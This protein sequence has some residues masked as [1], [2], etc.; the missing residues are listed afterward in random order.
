MHNLSPSRSGHKPRLC[1]CEDCGEDGRVFSYEQWRWHQTQAQRRTASTASRAVES[2]AVSATAAAAATS[3]SPSASLP[4]FLPLSPAQLAQSE[5]DPQAERWKRQRLGDSTSAEADPDDALL[6]CHSDDGEADQEAEDGDADNSDTLPPFPDLPDAVSSLDDTD[7]ASIDKPDALNANDAASASIED[8]SSVSSQA[9][10]FSLV[11][12]LLLDSNAGHFDHTIESV[13]QTIA[14]PLQQQRGR[15][16]MVNYIFVMYLMTF[17]GLSNTV[18]TLYLS[19]VLHVLSRFCAFVVDANVPTCT[20]PACPPPPQSP[21]QPSP[22]PPASVHRAH[23]SL[24]QASLQ[25]QASDD[26]VSSSLGREREHLS[27]SQLLPPPLSMLVTPASVRRRLGM[28]SDFDQYLVCPHCGELTLWNGTDPPRARSIRCA[29]G[30]QLLHN[31]TH[32]PL[33]LYCHRTLESIFSDVLMDPKYYNSLRDWVVVLEQASAPMSIPSDSSSAATATPHRVDSTH[34][35]GTSTH[36]RRYGEIITGPAWLEDC[37]SGAEEYWFGPQKGKFHEWHSTGAILLRIDN[38]PARLTTHDRRCLGT[39]LVGLLPG[40]RESSATRLQKFLDLI[41]DELLDFDL[42]GKTIKTYAQPEGELVKARLNLVVA[43]TPARAKVAG[44]ALK[45]PYFNAVDSCPPDIMH[46]VHLGLCKR[47]WHRFLIEQCDEIGKRLPEAQ[48]VIAN[49]MLPTSVQGPNKQIG[50]K[51]GGNPT[52]EQWEVLFRVLLPFVLMQLWSTSLSGHEDEALIFSLAMRGAQDQALPTASINVGLDIDADED[53][54]EPRAANDAG[55]RRLLAGQKRVRNVFRSAMLLCSVVELLAGDLDGDDVDMLD[56][57]I[58]KYNRSQSQLLGPGWLTFNN[59]N[60]TH[61]PHFIRRFGSPRHFSSLPFERFN[62]LMGTIPTSGHKGGVLEATIMRNASQRLELRRLLAKSDVPFF[63]T[64]LLQSI[65]GHHPSDLSTL[66]TRLKKKQLDNTTFGLLLDHLNR[67]VATSVEPSS[68]ADSNANANDSGRSQANNASASL[69]RYTPYWDTRASSNVARLNTQ[70]EFIRTA[71]LEKAPNVVDTIKVGG[72]GQGGRDNRRNCW[73]LVMVDGVLRAAKIL[74]IFNKAIRLSSAALDVTP[75]WFMHVRLLPE[76][77]L[78]VLGPRHP[79][80]SLLDGMGIRLAIDNGGEYGEEV[81]T[82]SSSYHLPH[83][84][85]PP[86]LLLHCDLRRILIRS[87]NRSIMPAIVHSARMLN[88][89][90]T[91]WTLTVVA[92]YAM[93]N[94]TASSV[95]AF[96]TAVSA[97]S[98]AATTFSNAATSYFSNAATAFSN[99]AT[100]YFSNG[101]I[102][103]LHIAHN[104]FIFGMQ[105]LSFTVFTLAIALTLVGLAWNDLSMRNITSLATIAFKSVRTILAASLSYVL[106]LRSLANMRMFLG[107]SSI[108]AFKSAWILAATWLYKMRNKFSMQ[109]ELCPSSNYCMTLEIKHGPSGFTATAIL[110]S[111][112]SALPT[113]GIVRLATM[114]LTNDNKISLMIRR[115]L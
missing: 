101:W 5:P 81:V 42:R 78:E 114:D 85:P 53:N 14:D 92:L 45:L 95:S 106:K 61:L 74:W 97:F 90:K 79:C 103:G 104:C 84:P 72:I 59:H 17:H 39:H 19:F 86:L 107:V 41:V 38:L 73:C 23:D 91:L 96:S 15:F 29:C 12:A 28:H 46:A 65:E 2:R 111:S 8:T 70:A 68:A 108:I 64:R 11:R 57:Y 60:V 16:A 52:A 76:V 26:F 50:S 98:N 33:Q 35:R 69:P 93:R 31:H 55:N 49:A 4:I 100:S 80:Q 30:A 56:N 21:S 115:Q 1:R 7:I 25:S 18:A 3:T 22:P 32:R 6:A 83:H 54:A 99:A 40:P 94:T 110:H 43:D 88:A 109:V 62:G 87:S 34:N 27:S 51:S 67:R 44:F 24:S 105:N 89:I 58:H 71:T 9:S 13:E 66:D 102:F 37:D 47:F 77:S 63:E 82:F 20:A 75:Q 10:R 48:S 112:T 36:R 113:D